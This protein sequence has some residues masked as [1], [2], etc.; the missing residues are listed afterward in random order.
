MLN[1]QIHVHLINFRINILRLANVIGH[2]IYIFIPW[3]LL[4]FFLSPNITSQTL[5]VYH[6]STHG[7]ALV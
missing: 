2:A 7:V 6:T 5:D 4:S 3:F 1:A